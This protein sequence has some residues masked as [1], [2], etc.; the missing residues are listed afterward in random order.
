MKI[1]VAPCSKLSDPVCRPS[2]CLWLSLFDLSLRCRPL[3]PIS[4][5]ESP[6]ICT[7]GLQGSAAPFLGPI[8]WRQASRFRQIFQVLFCPGPMLQFHALFTPTRARGTP[9]KSGRGGSGASPAAANNAVT[10]SICAMPSST[11]RAPP[12]ASSAGTVAA[13]AR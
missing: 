11:T 3:E 10:G 13:I 8:P 7:S 12:G 4:G 1:S 5:S 2:G 6:E 9:F